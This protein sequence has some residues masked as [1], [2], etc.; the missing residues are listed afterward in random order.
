MNENE[1][2]FTTTLYLWSEIVVKPKKPHSFVSENDLL[3]N[4]NL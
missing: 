3:S 4:C 1:T 2:Q